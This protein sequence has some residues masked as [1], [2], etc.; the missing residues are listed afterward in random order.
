MQDDDQ[1][2]F[3]KRSGR[4]A[5]VG[6]SVAKAGAK[7]VGAR[8]R[9]D[10][11]RLLDAGIIRAALGNLKG[12]LMKIAQLLATIPDFLPQEYAGELATLQSDAPSMGWPFVRRRMASELGPD[13]QAKFQS[14][15]KSACSAASLG[16]VHRAVSLDGKPLA[17]KLQYPNMESTVEADLQQLKILF[18]LFEQFDK[19]IS[20]QEAYTE[21]AARLREELDYRREAQSM[22]LYADMLASLP[23]AHVPSPVP[24]LSTTR[25]LTM[26]W[27]DGQKMLDA[28]ATRPQ[29]ERDAIAINMFKLWY[30]PFY[31]FGVIHGDPHL[32]NYTVREDCSINLLDFGCIRI[33][34]PQLV[35]AVVMLYHALRDN[36]EAQAVEAYRLWGFSD[37]SKE[38]L[39]VLTIWARFIYAPLLVDSAR[40]IEETNATAY[41]RETAAKVHRELK[42]LGGIAIPP[43]FVMI[44]RASIGLGSVFLRLKA[45]VNWYRLFHDMTEGFDVQALTVRQADI[46]KTHR[47]DY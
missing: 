26:S 15:D 17:C 18:A 44:D 45:R 24:D 43:E 38:M 22:S 35:Q 40:P 27:L 28:A 6:G 16:Q 32:G 14:F 34:K 29:E 25:L 41:G 8:L 23:E 3:I 12:P 2:S 11:S 19:T 37:L 30:R 4:Y 47:L 21:I 1:N 9:G 20:T 46:L 33:F 5:N 36:D 10:H 31:H 42:K 7:M 39:E 13:W